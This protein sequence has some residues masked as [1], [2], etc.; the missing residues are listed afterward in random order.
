MAA[1]Y[2]HNAM[3]VPDTQETRVPSP[4]SRT[5]S[6]G[7]LRTI[8]TANSH[9]TEPLLR[10]YPNTGTSTYH[11]MLSPVRRLH[12]NGTDFDWE[13]NPHDEDI[14]L[15][16]GSKRRFTVMRVVQISLEVILGTHISHFVFHGY[17]SLLA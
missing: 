9:P 2:L 14:R 1:L 4:H 8:G 15:R 12:T 3:F 17:F 16:K 6:S 5:I 13:T 11:D 7:T 10:S